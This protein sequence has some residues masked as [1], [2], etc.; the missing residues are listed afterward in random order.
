MNMPEQDEIQKLHR[1]ITS[2]ERRSKLAVYAMVAGIAMLF[3]PGWKKSA[4]PEVLTVRQLNIVD[5]HGI[6]R[7][8]LAAPLE[9]PMV[10]GK[11]TDRR[12]AA[13]GLALND[14]S[15]TEVGGL[16]M[17][18]DGTTALCFDKNL[19][20]RACLYITPDGRARLLLQDQRESERIGL[21]VDA[22]GKSSLQFFDDHE[23]PFL[24]IPE[25]AS[26]H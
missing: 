1:R 12:S 23:K 5:D 18:D 16:V 20:D 25:P 3:M 17:L 19:K 2:L 15:G 26:P 24:T 9:G 10:G 4:Q 11:P 6:R 7:L 14:A 21:S 22:D 8:I 13:T